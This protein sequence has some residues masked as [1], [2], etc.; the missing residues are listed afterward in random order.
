MDVKEHSYFGY[1]FFRWHS[2]EK[3]LKITELANVET[4]LLRENNI[5]F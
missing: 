4:V 1:D 2:R 3:R 5:F